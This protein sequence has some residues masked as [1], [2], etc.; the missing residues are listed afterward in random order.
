MLRIKQRME[1]LEPLASFRRYGANQFILREHPSLVQGRGEI[2]A[3]IY[4]M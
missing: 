1:L 3:G 4:E 2:E